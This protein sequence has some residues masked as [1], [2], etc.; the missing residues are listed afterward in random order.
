MKCEIGN[1]KDAG[2][3]FLEILRELTAIQSGG[4]DTLGWCWPK[5]GI[6]AAKFA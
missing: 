2:E 1:G 6:D 5:E 4:E 3:C